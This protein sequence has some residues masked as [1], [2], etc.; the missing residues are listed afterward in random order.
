MI[1]QYIK[2]RPELQSFIDNYLIVHLVFDKNNPIPYKAYP[3]R[4]EQALIFYARGTVTAENPKTR[5]YYLPY[6]IIVL[7]QQINKLNFHPTSEYLMV[8]VN[9]KPGALYR[10]LSIPNNELTDNFLDAGAVISN[11]ISQINEQLANAMNY[12]QIIDI[13]NLYLLNKIKK[14]KQDTYPVEK[15]ANYLLANPIQFS[16]D[17]LASEACLC[18]R[19]FDRKFKEHM[20]IGPKL[21]SRIVRFNQAY[22]FKEANPSASW[23]SIAIQAGYN[24]YQHLVKDFKEFT[25]VTPNLWLTENYKSPKRILQL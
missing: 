23:F 2:P 20:G 6:P 5:K 8:K 25:N 18:P 17:R 1:Y 3:P 10:L 21:F 16:L 14:V 15:V 22:Q 19:Q 7:G 11:E 9:F 24:D 4:A 12:E 13:V